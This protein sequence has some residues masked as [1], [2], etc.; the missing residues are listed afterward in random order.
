MEEKELTL[1]LNAI[2]SEVYG[3]YEANY[4]ARML[5]AEP[6]TD[7]VYNAKEYLE[8]N[9]KLLWLLKEPYCEGDGTG[10]GWDLVEE[11]NSKKW[12]FPINAFKRPTWANMAYVSYSIIEDMS[13]CDVPW[14]NED[15]YAVNKALLKVAHI[16]INKMPAGTRSNTNEV[17]NQ[18]SIWKDIIFKQIQAINPEVIICG[19]T[20]SIIGKDLPGRELNRIEVSP[21]K[22]FISYEHD[23]QLIIDAYHPAQTIIQREVYVDSIKTL[24]DQWALL[25]N[26]TKR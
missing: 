25:R 22:W 5:D 19:N 26:N 23:S 20:F 3:V 21:G 17:T 9:I 6:I 7:G 16:N 24:V 11:A 12:F 2:N 4:Q 1:R 18:Y 10:G 15:D 13:Y 8:S 14:I